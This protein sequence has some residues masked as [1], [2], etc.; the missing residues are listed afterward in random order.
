[1]RYEHLALQKV[2]VILGMQAYQGR[3]SK[4][5]SVLE[6]WMKQFPCLNV[7]RRREE[8][9]GRGR[10]ERVREEEEGG[11]RPYKKYKSSWGCRHTKGDTAK[12]LL[13]WRGG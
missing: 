8:G 4:V 10:G 11:G 1:M 12:W 3:Y 6:R 9:E 7:C 2:Q 5:A 13:Y